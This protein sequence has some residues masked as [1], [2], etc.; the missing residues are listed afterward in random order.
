M[1][2]EENPAVLI[3][4]NQ[5]EVSHPIFSESPW[6]LDRSCA[7]SARKRRQRLNPPMKRSRMAPKTVLMSRLVSRIRSS[8]TR[9]SVYLARRRLVR[10]YLTFSAAKNQSICSICP[11]PT[12]PISSKWLLVPSPVSETRKM[13][14]TSQL[15]MAPIKACKLLQNQQKE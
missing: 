10:M 11:N 3:M 8:L 15:K 7:P 2:E 1:S 9:R 14:I 4:T 6:R 5:V 13:T 12:Q